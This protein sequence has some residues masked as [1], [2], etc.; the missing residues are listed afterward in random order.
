MKVVFRRATVSPSGDHFSTSNNVL[1][2]SNAKQETLASLNIQISPKIAS[3][4]WTFLDEKQ[5]RAR[6]LNEIV[7]AGLALNVFKSALDSDSN[8]LIVNAFVKATE[9][10][11]GI[12]NAIRLAGPP[13]EFPD[14]PTDKVFFAYINIDYPYF[15]QEKRNLFD[16][17]YGEGSYTDRV[18]GRSNAMLPVK[19]L[20][21]I[22][23]KSSESAP[24]QRNADFKPMP[25][26]TSIAGLEIVT[27][28][29][30]RI[31]VTKSCSS[32]LIHKTLVAISSA[33]SQGPASC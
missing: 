11:L 2:A 1:D 10:R 26:V 23:L 20:K 6:G 13:K 25:S 22:E 16:N 17:A 5:Q 9:P 3:L 28:L 8:E 12:A 32:E 7:G 15:Y 4:F 24:L 14:L 19:V 30:L 29:G 31:I 27:P 33:D 18:N 21:S